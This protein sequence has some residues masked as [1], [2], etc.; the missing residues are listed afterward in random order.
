MYRMPLSNGLARYLKHLFYRWWWN[1]SHSI[2]YRYRHTVPFAYYFIWI[3]VL[4]RNFFFRFFF[5]HNI[6]F[7]INTAILFALILC[8]AFITVRYALI[9]WEKERKK[10]ADSKRAHDTIKYY[11]NLSSFTKSAYF[12]RLRW[13]HSLTLHGTM[14][15]NLKGE[16]KICIAMPSNH[17]VQKTIY[18]KK[19][20]IM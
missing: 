6:D 16:Q 10:K 20:K 3:I 14:P 11:K 12:V 13:K 4:W 17:T 2:L 8:H 9:M 15:E 18:E 5:L 1:K 19:K 7:R